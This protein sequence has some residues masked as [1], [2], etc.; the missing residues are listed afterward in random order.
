MLY[1]TGHVNFLALRPLQGGPKGGEKGGA[2]GGVSS[3]KV[4]PI[5]RQ[6]D[7]KNAIEPFDSLS[8]TLS[9]VGVM[10]LDLIYV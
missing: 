10:G 2:G 3:H 7:G 5:S 8:V 6:L 4:A 1:F 9:F